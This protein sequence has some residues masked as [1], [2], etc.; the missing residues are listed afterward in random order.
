[1]VYNPIYVANNF[2]ERSFRDKIVVT[3]MKLQKMLYFLYRDYLKETGERLFPEHFEAWEYGPALSMIY[4]KTKKYGK[5]F[6]YEYL[7]YDD[8]TMK[9]D[10]NKDPIF[11]KNINNI[12]AICSHFTGVELCKLTHKE[13]SAWR[14]AWSKGER[15]I[16]DEDIKNDNIRIPIKV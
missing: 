1:M 12:W 14:I 2:M 6:I 10:E 16:D 4:N 9:I 13:G 8:E 7:K 3:Q 5:H 15:Y 11:T